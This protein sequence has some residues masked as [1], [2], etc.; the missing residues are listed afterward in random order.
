[1][2]YPKIYVNKIKKPHME[3]ITLKE[4]MLWGGKEVDVIFVAM[5]PNSYT[6]LNVLG[7]PFSQIRQNANL[8]QRIKSSKSYDEM[9]KYV[10]KEV[11]K[12]F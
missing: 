2:A 4:P 6:T 11:E 8:V 9:I 1:A 10:Q 3:V 5:L 7:R 12:A